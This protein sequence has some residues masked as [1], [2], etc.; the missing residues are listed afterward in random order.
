MTTVVPAGLWSWRTARRHPL[1]TI[2][3]GYLVLLVAA[4]AAAPLIAP[5]D[6]LAQDLGHALAGPG[7]TYWLGTDQLGRDVTSRLLYGGRSA[8]MDVVTAVVTALAVG[9]PLGLV[10]GYLGGWVDRVIMRVADLIFAIPGIIVL[11][12]VVAIFPGNNTIAMITLGLLHTP[13]I[14]RVV[15]GSTIAGRGELFVRAAVLS[16]LRT[17]AILRRHLLPSL[18]GPI[19]VQASLFAAA[20]LV[21]ESGLSFLGLLRPDSAG[22]TWGN[23]V[24]QAANVSGQNPWLLV[25]TGGIVALTVVAFSLL[26]DAI[27]DATI[28]R[29]A[30]P[31]PLRS[32][33]RRRGGT[34][35]AAAAPGAG[36][37]DV[38]GLTVS[39]HRGGTDTTVV[40][41]VSFRLGSGECIGIVGESGCGK[42][43]TIRAIL[44]LLPAGGKVTAG[45][46]LFDGADLTRL[47]ERELSRRRGAGIA[48][49]SQDPLN[50]LDPVYTVGSQLR[51]AI[52]RHTRMTRAQADERAIELLR[53]VRFPD[54]GAVLPRRAHELSGG[55]AQRVGIAL[56]LA[57]NP[58]VLIADEPTSALDVT[59]QA[60]I[61]ALLRE[62]RERLG[63]AVIL[64]THDWGVLA[65]ICDRTLVMYAGQIVE[66]GTIEQVYRRPAHPYSDALLASY[67]GLAT[68]GRPLPTIAGNVPQP[69][70][71]PAGCHFGSRCRY[72]GDE[73]HA[74]DVSLVAVAA[75]HAAR[76][77]HTDALLEAR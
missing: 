34:D 29:S 44:G 59:V 16:G 73:C 38:R 40:S 13:G 56:A 74:G 71:W 31:V 54:P 25:P 57:A 28:G 53:M 2:C 43:T 8:L 27:R 69:G 48:L 17:P 52:R 33:P 30:P 41:D 77:L 21:V 64:V 62:L 35:V 46:V 45:A 39:L 75:D 12:M 50:G 20:A 65:D 58:K 11:L 22:P 15:R 23:L 4:L 42:S 5:H 55:M 9:V 68:V 70:R 47:S 60:E 72:A 6:P 36:V 10:G 49:V 1:G 76:C 32:A 37:L 67:P 51:E 18:A 14:A 3:A 26:G 19:I 7:S 61:L 24:T 63:M 66:T